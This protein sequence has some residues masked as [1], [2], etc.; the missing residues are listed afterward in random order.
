VYLC[1]CASMS[2]WRPAHDRAQPEIAAYRALQ[3]RGLSM[4]KWCMCIGCATAGIRDSYG[5]CLSHA[6]GRLSVLPLYDRCSSQSRC[7]Q[8]AALPGLVVLLCCTWVQ[9]LVGEGRVITRSCPQHGFEAAQP[10]LIVIHRADWRQRFFWSTLVIESNPQV[11]TSRMLCQTKH[12]ST[13]AVV[14]RN[15]SRHDRMAD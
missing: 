1:I 2:L 12:C 13:T 6:A 3:V 9:A 10:L 15:T 11:R 14:H 5:Q 7:C 8:T 4:A